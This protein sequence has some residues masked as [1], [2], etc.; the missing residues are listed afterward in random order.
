MEK[1]SNIERLRSK[2]PEDEHNDLVRKIGEAGFR[3]PA[4]N[5]ITGLMVGHIEVESSRANH[6]F[7]IGH[8][9]PVAYIGYGHFDLVNIDYLSLRDYHLQLGML[10]PEGE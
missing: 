9:L 5:Q 6:P 2:I 3:I 4:P 8:P 10:I 1:L 7:G